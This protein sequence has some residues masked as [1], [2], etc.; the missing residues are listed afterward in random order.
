MKKRARDKF[1]RRQM[2]E[3]TAPPPL[4]TEDKVLQVLEVLEVRRAAEEIRQVIVTAPDDDSSVTYSPQVP[5]VSAGVKPSQ[6]GGRVPGFHSGEGSIGRFE[7]KVR[8]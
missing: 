6:V 8:D 3:L 2:E 7:C 1:T 5:S 4:L